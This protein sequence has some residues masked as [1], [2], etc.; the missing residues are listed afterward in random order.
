MSLRRDDYQ[1]LYPQIPKKVHYKRIIMLQKSYYLHIF[2]IIGEAT[3][4]ADAMNNNIENFG[5]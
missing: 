3:M 4:P 5:V 1:I 2:V